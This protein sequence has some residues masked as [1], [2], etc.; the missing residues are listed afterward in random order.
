MFECKKLPIY[1]VHV[2]VLEHL[3]IFPSL[4]G[5]QGSTKN[6]RLLQT[7]F[8]RAL[9]SSSCFGVLLCISYIKLIT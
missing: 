7:C 8:S 3:S 9:F 5:D 2:L 4:L 6:G 1:F